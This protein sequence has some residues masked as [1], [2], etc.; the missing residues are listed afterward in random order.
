MAP[1]RPSWAARW[2]SR[3]AQPLPG[4][5]ARNVKGPTLGVAHEGHALVP[6]QTP[7]LRQIDTGRE[8]G[9]DRVNDFPIESA[10]RQGLFIRLR[11]THQGDA[12]GGAIDHPWFIAPGVE[13]GPVLRRPLQRPA[14]RSAP[15]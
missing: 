2:D 13:D 7:R 4:Q 1:A 12:H 3:L 14:V 9:V 11:E 5:G 6:G 8:V 10:L 15:D